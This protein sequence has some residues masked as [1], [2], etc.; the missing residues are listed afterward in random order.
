MIAGLL[1]PLSVLVAMPMLLVP[2]QELWQ[3]LKSTATEA[4][5][6]TEVWGQSNVPEART[7]IQVRGGLQ[8]NQIRGGR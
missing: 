4:W 5:T 2:E 7:I 1:R 8:V 3:A 6:E